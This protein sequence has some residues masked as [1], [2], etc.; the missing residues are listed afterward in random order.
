MKKIFLVFVSLVFAVSAN[1]VK[2]KGDDSMTIEKGKKVS[3]DYTLTVDGQV[4]D[5][6]K[7][8]EP[9]SYVHGEGKIIPGLASELE[10]MKE[11]QEKTVEVSP[12]DAY[13]K[14]DPEAFKEISKGSLPEGLEP[15]TGMMLQM[16][17]PEGQPVPVKVAEVKDEAV[18][19]DLNHPLAGKTLSF[20]V[21]VISVEQ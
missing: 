12:E 14:E 6:S 5:S 1:I 9:L 15:K 2:V 17:G 10:G 8:R 13:G 11:G 16:Q 7:E 20:D 19:L 21:K 4:V 18:V 3:F